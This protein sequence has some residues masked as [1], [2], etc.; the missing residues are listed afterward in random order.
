MTNEMDIEVSIN[1]KEI[2]EKYQIE[3]R[4]LE[5]KHE[6]ENQSLFS[7]WKNANKKERKKLTK[8]Y[9]LRQAKEIIKLIDK[10]YEMKG[11]EKI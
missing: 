7:I 1:H 10:F 11:G 4:R 5:L 2:F 3:K 9:G 8:M 6:L